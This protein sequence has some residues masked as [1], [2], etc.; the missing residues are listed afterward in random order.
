MPADLLGLGLGGR[1]RQ[2]LSVGLGL[3]G[4]LATN[5]FGAGG[6]SGESRAVICS[7]AVTIF[8]LPTDLD[9]NTAEIHL[10]GRMAHGTSQP[11]HF[12][13]QHYR[14]VDARTSWHVQTHLFGPCL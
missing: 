5:P 7:F 12:P 8:S 3:S 6:P 13:W 2:E 14:V 9:Q 4:P 1:K 11:Q 10:S